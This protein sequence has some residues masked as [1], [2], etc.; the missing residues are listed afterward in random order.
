MREYSA[1]IRQHALT[2]ARRKAVATCNR[3]CNRACST[4]CYRWLDADAHT[5]VGSVA[6]SI[7]GSVAALMLS[8]VEIA[9]SVR[10]HTLVGSVAG[11]VAALRADGLMQ[12]R[13]LKPQAHRERVRERELGG[14]G[15]AHTGATGASLSSYRI[16]IIPFIYLT[17]L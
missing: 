17:I 12:M 10:P 1:C 9:S 14:E 16:A 15:D 8:G 5:L 2:V 7:A 3:V 13:I 4:A 11:S 6:G